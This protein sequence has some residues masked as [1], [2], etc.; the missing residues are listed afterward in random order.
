MKII[1]LLKAPE[2]RNV[3]RVGS[4]GTSRPEFFPTPT[5]SGVWDGALHAPS[6]HVTHGMAHLP[7][8]A[9]DRGTPHLPAG[10]R[11]PT[12]TL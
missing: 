6:L 2:A 7:K 10:P 11:A 4:H 9:E 5:L 1:K 8:D 12:H 3:R